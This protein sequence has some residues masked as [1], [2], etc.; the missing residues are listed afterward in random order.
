MVQAALDPTVWRVSDGV[1]FT[2]IQLAHDNGS[3]S[4]PDTLLCSEGNFAGATITKAVNIIGQGESKTRING[5]LTIN[6]DDVEVAY[7]DWQVDAIHITANGDDIYVHH[8]IFENVGGSTTQINYQDNLRLLVE[9]CTFIG[10]Q[11]IVGSTSAANCSMVV[12]ECSFLA[13]TNQAIEM[14]GQSTSF[15]GTLEVIDCVI[16]DC[17]KGVYVWGETTAVVKGTWI[18]GQITASFGAIDI[19]STVSGTT[20]TLTCW[21]C[22]FLR[23]NNAIW[24]TITG[25]GGATFSADIHNCSFMNNTLDAGTPGGQSH[26]IDLTHNYWGQGHTGTPVPST[27]GGGTV[28]ITFDPW[29]GVPMTF[30]IDGGIAGSVWDEPIEDHDVQGTMGWSSALAVYNGGP[31]GPGIYVNSGA[32]NTNTV[33]GTDGTLINPVST[34]AAAKTLADALGLA[35]FYIRGNSSLTLAATMQDYIFV[36]MGEVTANV[37]N[38]GNQ[39]VSR[40]SFFNITLEGTQSGT[41]RIFAV[42][43]ALQKQTAGSTTLHIFASC[44]GIVDQ[45]RVD[46][47]EDNVF[48]ACYSL[49]AGVSTPIIIA[50]GAAGTISVRHYSGGIEFQSL[51]ASHNLSVEGPGQVIFSANCNVNATVAIRGNM[52]I[53]DNT[54][55]MNSISDDARI[56]V[57]QI[58]AECDAA[59]IDYD[60]PTK[61][62]LDTAES[63]IRGADSDDL[64]VISDQLDNIEPEAEVR[65][66]GP[67]FMVV[68]TAQD[69]LNG[70]LAAGETGELVVNDVSLFTDWGYVQIESEVVFYTG[71]D[72]ANDKLT[73]LTR[74]VFGTSDVLHVDASGVYQAVA[75]RV[76]LTVHDA[77][78]PKAPAGIPTLEAIN[79]AGV[80]KVASGNM[81]QEGAEVGIYYTDIILKSDEV[82]PQIW[83][84]RITVI[85]V[86]GKTN[87][88][89]EIL[90][91]LDKPASESD[92]ISEVTPSAL[93]TCTQDG[94]YDGS[95][96]FQAWPDALVG[97]MIDDNGNALFRGE[98]RFYRKVGGVPIHQ[99]HPPGQAYTDVNG[100]WTALVPIGTFT[101]HS[102]KDGVIDEEVERVIT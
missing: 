5:T 89:R 71:R 23:N 14:F 6:V 63:N 91:V 57:D 45:I 36:G 77:G 34:I 22:H 79:M 12:K 40:C 98:A 62:E 74:G 55:G 78:V 41:G 25:G 42:C 32:G 11:G 97:S 38:L 24:I 16:K 100:D 80:T 73:T 72:T 29:L 35:T 66:E 4:A 10:S 67:S 18:I 30:S 58:N 28:T 9:N 31:R 20:T 59:L 46:T 56:D 96:V 39:D 53:T 81:T 26:T 48:D 44:C 51:S 17:G 19:R 87:K 92:V 15:L 70:A 90:L 86:A 50:T 76:K 101:Y 2:T 52:T 69:N 64:K 37:I 47:S 43:C 102:W 68:P 88:Y 60:P 1:A 27:G 95:F 21:N 82:A 85:P 84:V 99:E 65:I 94:Y 7:L 13:Q 75:H 33:V 49:V 3:T 8:C 93:R 54:A 83:D 61:A